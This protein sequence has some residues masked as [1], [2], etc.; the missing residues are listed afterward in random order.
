MIRLEDHADAVER[1]GGEKTRRFVMTVI[2]ATLMAATTAYVLG[3]AV[4]APERVGSTHGASAA[5]QHA[6]S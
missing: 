3:Y 2:V 1:A 6:R 5:A 4:T